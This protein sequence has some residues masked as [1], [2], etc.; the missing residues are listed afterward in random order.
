MCG[1]AGI[2]SKTN[3]TQIIP[4]LLAILT[5]LIDRGQDGTGIGYIDHQGNLVIKKK[6]V[7]ALDFLEENKNEKVE[8]N[9]AI[10]HVRFP[11]VGVTSKFNSHP[12]LDCTGNIAVAHNGTI[13][14][15]RTLQNELTT[16]G[17]IFLSSVDS[18]V[19]PHLIEK[20]F[21]KYDDL[22]KSIRKT[23]DR[24]EGYYTFTVISNFEPDKV[25]LYRHHFPLVLVKDEN[26][27]YFSS[28]RSPLVKL[29]NKPIRAKH[30]KEGELLA[31]S[32]LD[33]F[34]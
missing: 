7:S 33:S 2:L 12:L 18:E 22:E 1:I 8:C 11:T 10:G 9:I 4:N 3:S 5:N 26:T 17:H 6:D 32:Y 24:L 28:D 19:I 13:K 34:D 31:L 29:L 25:Y 23:I 30:L 15:Y 14:N 20:Y 16:E 21:E 27:Y